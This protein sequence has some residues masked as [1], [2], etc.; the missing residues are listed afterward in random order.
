[1]WRRIL[2]GLVIAALFLGGIAYFVDLSKFRAAASKVHV[3][4][5]GLVLL[6]KSFASWVKGE[7]WRI[8]MR[9][10][11][12][13]APKHTF[14]ATV[15]GLLGNLIFPARLGEVL[16]AQIVQKNNKGVSRSLALTS[17]IL[18]QLFDVTLLLCCLILGTL[19]VQ[20]AQLQIWHLVGVVALMLSIFGGLL[21]FE[22][23]YLRFA[24]LGGRL[25]AWLPERIRQLL[26][27]II[28]QVHQGLGLLRKPLA[29]LQ[30]FAWALVLWHI[31]ALCY[32]LL[33]KALGLQIPFGMLLL[34]T[35]AAN[36]A[37]LL[38]LTP[39]AVGVHQAVCIW[40]LGFAGIPRETSFLYSLLMQGCDVL[41]IV[42]LGGFFFAQEGLKMGQ[43]EQQIETVEAEKT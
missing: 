12:G 30:V 28:G 17:S 34:V 33:L 15:I 16:R 18:A 26:A 11:L 40:V 1:M 21:I 42:S 39:G 14:S 29:V 7:R 35:G 5:L 36:L 19:L 13:W 32:F 27:G 8:A 41:M 23:F 9:A 2:P 37:F 43:M 10:V 24:A 25:G 6:L 31:E 22:V 3:A 4:W 38:P 20:K